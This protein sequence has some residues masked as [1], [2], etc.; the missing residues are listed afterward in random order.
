MFRRLY[1][2]LIKGIRE[3]K[4]VNIYKTAE[5]GNGC[6]IG[7]YVEIGDKVEIGERCKLGAY[8]FIPK[9]VKIGKEVFIGP[10]VKFTN[11]LY[12]KAV[13]EWKVRNTVVHDG[14][15]IGAG[16]TIICGVK[17]GKNAKIGAGSVVTK[18]VKEDEVVVGV[19][20]RPIKSNWK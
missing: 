3:Y 10:A 15:S 1:R 12:P 14:A 2:K 20:A 8:V 4:Y 18:D 9:G 17:I 16:S 5:I 19:P 6:V 11:D 13:G 7:S